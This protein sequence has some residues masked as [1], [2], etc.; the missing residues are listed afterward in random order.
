M[1]SFVVIEEKEALLSG[2]LPRMARLFAEYYETVDNPQSFL[3]KLKNCGKRVDLFTFVQS[4][5]DRTPKYTF[6]MEWDS[7]AV[8]PISNYDEWWKKQ[9]KDK[10]RNMVRRAEKSGVVLRHVA[11][12]DDLVRGIMAI[13]NESPL[14]Q[15]KRFKHYGKSF[16]A[17]KMENAS[18]VDR[19][20]FV[21]AYLGDEL[22][23]FIK[24]VHG[25]GA[26]NLMQILCKTAHRDKAP[27]NALL[28]K[29]VELCAAKNIPN[30]HYGVWSRRGIGEFKKH[31]GFQLVQVPRYFVPLNIAGKVGLRLGF[32]RKMMDYIPENL[33]DAFATW[34]SRYYAIKFP[35]NSSK[36]GL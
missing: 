14:R 9:I 15:G 5:V 2:R 18:F 22:V 20:D 35:T 24:L 30:L 16:E 6:P 4:V 10:T 12:D 25:N 27:T 11:Y 1:N 7:I 31:N 21:G 29:A 13:Y 32:H 19:S 36:K 17:V 8:L 23:G 26:S 34:R 33:Q 3:D 28:A